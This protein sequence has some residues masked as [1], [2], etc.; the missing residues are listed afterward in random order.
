MVSIGLCSQHDLKQ[1]ADLV[2]VLAIDL[3]RE[4]IAVFHCDR[5]PGA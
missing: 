1:I 5:F 4:V 3:G 2:C